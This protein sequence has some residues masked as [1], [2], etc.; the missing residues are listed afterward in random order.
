MLAEAEATAATTRRQPINLTCKTCDKPFTLRREPGTRGRYPHRCEPCG[1]AGADRTTTLRFPTCRPIRRREEGRCKRCGCAIP[2]TGSKARWCC[3]ACKIARIKEREAVRTEREREARPLRQCRD[4]G[5]DIARSEKGGN[6]LRCEPCRDTAYRAGRAK[7]GALRQKRDGSTPRMVL[8]VRVKEKRE[9]DAIAAAVR[10]EKWLARKA[11]LLAEKPWRAVGLTSGERFAMRYRLDPA[12]NLTQRLRAAFKRRRQ[13]LKIDKLLRAALVRG[14][15]SPS[16]ER[17]VGYSVA[18]LK[19]HL[20]RQFTKRMTW[21]RFCAGDIH[22]DHIRP[23]T[24]FKL[25]DP[26]ELRAAWA[27]SNLQPLWARDNLAKA[28]RV[29]TLL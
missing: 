1:A 6:V 20:E 15:K 28:A 13:G 4:C 11:A 17:F 23:L 8:A 2:K 24:K 5:A 26:E 25:A 18:R 7:D 10:R 9:R 12:F 22:I 16:V 3:D 14:G 19:Q 21:E 29:I 27:L